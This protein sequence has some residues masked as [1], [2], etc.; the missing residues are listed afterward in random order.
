MKINP[1]LLDG[2]KDSNLLKIKWFVQM[3]NVGSHMHLEE[4][5]RMPQHLLPQTRC[6]IPMPK[7][8]KK[9]ATTA[10]NNTA[11]AKRKKT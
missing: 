10:T 6:D 7:E 9:K 4:S 8:R 2:R 11:A 3:W 1:G 5:E